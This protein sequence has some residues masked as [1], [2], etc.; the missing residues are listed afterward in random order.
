M[1]DLVVAALIRQLAVI[2]ADRVAQSG[3]VQAAGED[4]DELMKRAFEVRR[5]AR[6]A[7][8]EVRREYDAALRSM[9]RLAQEQIRDEPARDG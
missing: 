4:L 2:A 8:E 3:A 1:M 6:D 7:S 5:M 9:M